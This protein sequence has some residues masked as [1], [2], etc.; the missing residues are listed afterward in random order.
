MI[1]H[2]Q[3]KGQIPVVFEDTL[4]SSCARGQT[5]CMNGLGPVDLYCSSVLGSLRLLTIVLA[6]KYWSLW[7]GVRLCEMAP[8][9]LKVYWCSAA[10]KIR[11]NCESTVV[12]QEVETCLCTQAAIFITGQM[13]ISEFQLFCHIHCLEMLLAGSYLGQM[14]ALSIQEIRLD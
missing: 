6:L 8:C 4:S 14:S 11:K 1:Q 7:L 5:S 13:N 3:S 2:W 9:Q 12:L 10:W